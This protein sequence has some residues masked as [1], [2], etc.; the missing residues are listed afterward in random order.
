MKAGYNQ[1]LNNNNYLKSNSVSISGMKRLFK[2]IDNNLNDSDSDEE[3]KERTQKVINDKFKSSNSNAVI[4]NISKNRIKKFNVNRSNREKNN[5][6]RKM[7]NPN[8]NNN[9][10]FNRGY[11]AQINDN[12]YNSNNY[13][14]VKRS[15]SGEKNYKPMNNLYNLTEE[16]KYN[17]INRIT[18]YTIIL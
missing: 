12:F 3:H 1:N 11:S 13:T 15:L 9:I 7:D 4:D 5:M 14:N 8:T 6:K 10:N 18:S 2:N 16:K 17:S